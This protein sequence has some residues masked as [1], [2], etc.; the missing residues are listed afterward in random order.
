M[1]HAVTVSTSPRF[2]YEL[3]RLRQSFRSVKWFSSRLPAEWFW[4]MWGG[5]VRGR[6]DTSGER[7]WTPPDPAAARDSSSLTSRGVGLKARETDWTQLDVNS[8]EHD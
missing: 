4:G 2:I 3:F 1:V 8:Q 6:R 5:G 7:T